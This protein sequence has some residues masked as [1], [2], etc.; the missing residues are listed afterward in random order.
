MRQWGHGFLLQETESRKEEKQSEMQAPEEKSRS[1][2]LSCLG[3][4][5][6][7]HWSSHFKPQAFEDVLTTYLQGFICNIP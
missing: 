7:S 1:R 5:A 4:T 3:Q 2:F 6:F